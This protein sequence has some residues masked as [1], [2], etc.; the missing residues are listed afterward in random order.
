MERKTYYLDTINQSSIP[1]EKRTTI[2]LPKTIS[3]KSPTKDI[4]NVIERIDMGTF[5]QKWFNTWYIEKPS[6]LKSSDKIRYQIII[7]KVHLLKL[8]HIKN[9]TGLKM[10]D[11]VYL[12]PLFHKKEVCHWQT[13]FYLY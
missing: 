8:E 6:I 9:Q 2:S 1:Q 12:A 10:N 3:I 4:I 5:I 13:S 11:I 7:N